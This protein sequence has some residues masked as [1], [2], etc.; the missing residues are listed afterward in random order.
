MRTNW[1][2]IVYL[3]VWNRRRGGGMIEW[4]R[5]RVELTEQ[6]GLLGQA[7]QGLSGVPQHWQRMRPTQST[8]FE[9]KFGTVELLF[10]WFIKGSFIGEL[11][12]FGQQ[13]SRHLST[14]GVPHL[15]TSAHPAIH[16][17]KP[18]PSR[19]QTQTSSWHVPLL[20][21]NKINH[22]MIRRCD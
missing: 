10:D 21:K 8:F 20:L 12:F 6:Q 15:Q 18:V 17:Q 19:Q 1:N 11:T 7:Q 5:Y 14:V 13:K 9:V 3:D 22:S 2:R 4:E 16:W